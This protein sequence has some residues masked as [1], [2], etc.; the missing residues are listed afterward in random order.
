MYSFPLKIVTVLVRTQH[1]THLIFDSFHCIPASLLPCPST[2]LSDLSNVQHLLSK[3]SQDEVPQYCSF[4][5]YLHGAAFETFCSVQTDSEPRATLI[6]LIT[7][8]SLLTCSFPIV[9][10][11]TLRTVY[12][13]IQCCTQ[14]DPS[15]SVGLDF[16]YNR[17][18][19]VNLFYWCFWIGFAEK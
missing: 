19:N 11:S 18:N 12:M 6:L 16:C 10:Y 15:D 4:R 17:N 7:M 9:S 1:W 13:C 3:Q 14:R 5:S 8:S 2:I